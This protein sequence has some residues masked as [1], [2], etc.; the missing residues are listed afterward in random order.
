MSQVDFSQS[1]SHLW[2]QF[3]RFGNQAD[4]A[5]GES[6]NA[7]GRAGGAGGACFTCGELGHLARDCPNKGRAKPG[8]GAPV[9]APNGS[10]LALKVPPI[11]QCHYMTLT[12]ESPSVC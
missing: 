5:A 12:A 11:S 10:T 9:G 7:G 1:V 8:G 3:K 6:A 4:A 2:R